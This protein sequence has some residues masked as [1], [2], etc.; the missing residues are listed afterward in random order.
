[1]LFLTDAAGFVAN[2]YR[3]DAYGRPLDL[4]ETVENP[5]LYTAREF[6]PESGLY[7][8][9]ARAYD[10]STGRF[11]QEDPIHFAAGD[12]NL[13]RYV[14]NNPVNL[15]DPSGLFTGVTLLDIFF[16]PDPLDLVCPK[17]PNSSAEQLKDQWKEDVPMEPNI[18]SEGSQPDD[19]FPPF[20]ETRRP[21]P[22]AHDPDGPKAPGKPGEAEGF[23]EPKGG[24]QW[25]KNPSGPGYGWKD[26][27]GNVWVPTGKGAK[28][29][30]GPHWDVQLPGGG[31][32]NVYPGGRVR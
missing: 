24:E 26:R 5:Y 11:L 25:A 4:I 30:G 31:H 12:L 28:A 7:H 23:K 10:P 8:Y 21:P 17:P 29:H 22:D 13:Y 18:T 27:K 9:R 16:P 15:T 6:D 1:M 19:D 14:A 32:V 2:D 20:V 3:Y